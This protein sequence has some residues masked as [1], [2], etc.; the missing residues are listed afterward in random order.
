MKK[1]ILILLAAVLAAPALSGKPGKAPGRL[2]GPVVV[3]TFDDAT[4]SQRSVVAPLLK[5]YGYGATFYV[6]EFPGFEDKTKYMSWEQIGELNEMGFE[7]GN[8]G[9]RHGA[10]SQ[11]SRSAIDEDIAYIERKCA[12]YGIPRPVTY[13]YPGYDTSA[14]GFAVLRERGY[15]L[16]RV[17]GDEPYVQGKFDSLLMPSYGIVDERVE[18]PGFLEGMLDEARDGQAVILCLHGVPDLA[19]DFVSTSP[20]N[21]E[22]LLRVLKKR[23]C[24]VISMRDLLGYAL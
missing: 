2:K 21:F 8:H 4:Q 5:K 18:T 16:A 11:M 3:L 17:G 15:R 20:E 9:Q 22:K 7:I 10:M 6:C 23:K 12:E 1:A 19:H 13:A 14:D 24:R